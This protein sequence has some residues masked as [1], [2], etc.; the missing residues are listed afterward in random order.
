MPVSRLSYR[1]LAVTAAIALLTGVA[2]AALAATRPSRP[3]AAPAT[4]RPAPAAGRLPIKVGSVSMRPCPGESLAWCGRINVPYQYGQPKAGT[5]KLG[6]MWYPAAAGTPDGT[7]LAVQG[8]P[9]YATT[10][11]ATDYYDLF[12]RGGTGGHL[13]LLNTEN[14]LLVNLRGTGNSSPF[15][16]R[17]LQDWTV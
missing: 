3:P 12:A 16:C 5:I 8:G 13:S 11:Y 2:P 7:V 15:T 17:A 9:G 14:L 1:V 10:D 6:F 4:S